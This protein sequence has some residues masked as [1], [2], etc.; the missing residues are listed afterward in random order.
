[1]KKY[2]NLIVLGVLIIAAAAFFIIREVNFNN[3]LL[4][5]GYYEQKISLITTGDVHGHLVYDQANG[6]YYT[7]D[8]I[9]IE[10]GMPLMKAVIDDEKKKNKNS[11]VLDS[12][13][14]FHGT[15]EA[16]VNESEGIVE[17][18]NL[19]GYDAMVAG[20][21]DFDF[22]FD[23]IM[24]I[25]SKLNYPMLAANV[26]KDGQPAFEQYKIF[27]VGG[28]KIG[29]F[30]LTIPESL[31]NMAVFGKSTVEFTDQIVAAKRVVADLES[32]KVDSIILLS[33]LGDDLDK[34][35]I[36]KVD[37][38][39]FILSGHHHWLYKKA[40]KINNT[41]FAE[42]GS[43]TTHVG[44]ADLYYKKGKVAKVVWSIHNSN[45]R[46]K[47]D[48][49]IAAVAKKYYDIAFEKG[50]EVI[51]K[52]SVVLNGVRTQ[53]RSQETNLADLIADA[54]KEQGGADLALLNGGG[55]R[56]SV[57]KG[58]LTLYN[59]GKPLPF[60][61][62]LMTVEVTGQK[63]YDALERGLREW[64]NGASNGGFLQVSGISYE[65]D[66]SKPAGK[67]LV[68]V[69][70]DGKPLDKNK[71][72]KVATNDYLADGGDNYDEFKDAKL[73]SKGELLRDV[74]AKYIK[75]K[76]NVSPGLDG[77]IKVINQR[78]K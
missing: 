51:G 49:T 43:Y 54:M 18:A 71:L 45:D 21:H 65:I 32:Q 41:Y 30:G 69:T 31:S 50:K 58:D 7:L 47:E 57:P 16:N 62:S 11:L 70:K 22:G 72:F 6:G 9:N 42:P 60:V 34:E 67:R 37:G 8:E 29:V 55:I 17:A 14:M 39:D 74:L 28:K 5:M 64:P 59:I 36:K 68:S 1:M 33:H 10:M 63:V 20:N 46:S 2:T 56:E 12:G 27:N 15:N 78:Y 4:S 3:L 38:I 53:V 40:E 75:E 13:D 48:K 77:R 19:M 24:Q 73:I 26:S 44:V 52:S 66:G 25:K 61:N 35:L 76:G 23:R